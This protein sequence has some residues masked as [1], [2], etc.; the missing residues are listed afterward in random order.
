M[1]ASSANWPEDIPGS[2]SLIV[3]HNT[4]NNAE[5]YPPNCPLMLVHR[6]R[7]AK[8]IYEYVVI[9]LSYSLHHQ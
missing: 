4:L 7:L 3:A 8:R 9:V 1:H 2:N 5:R 6:K